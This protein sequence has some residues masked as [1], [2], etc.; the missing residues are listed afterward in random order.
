MNKNRYNEKD[1]GIALDEKTLG[2][3]LTII[4]LGLLILAAILYYIFK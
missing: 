4:S 1:S 3:M 2:F